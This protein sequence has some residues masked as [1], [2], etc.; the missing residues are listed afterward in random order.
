MINLISILTEEKDA[1]RYERQGKLEFRV[2]KNVDI[3]QGNIIHIGM[4]FKSLDDYEMGSIR[5]LENAP[6]GDLG[7]QYPKPNYLFVDYIAVETKGQ[8][9]GYLLYK[10]ALKYAKEHK[11]K[12]IVSHHSRSSDADKIWGKLKT[13]SDKNYDYVDIKDLGTRLKEAVTPI[14]ENNKYITTY[15]GNCV[16]LIKQFGG[17][18]DG[19]AVEWMMDNLSDDDAVSRITDIEF[20]GYVNKE[21]VPKKALRGKNTE[22]Y[23]IKTHPEHPSG[24]TC[25]FLL[26]TD[27][28]IGDVH[29]FFNVNG[30]ESEPIFNKILPNAYGAGSQMGET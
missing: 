29:Y 10:A 24:F 16:S 13:F 23:F 15:L 4:Y 7:I 5:L 30:L 26:Y 21:A 2:E 25:N 9:Y 27:V 22:Y 1:I 6:A 20:F 19:S 28:D 3:H 14:G 12:G 17:H 8:G 18:D 11:F